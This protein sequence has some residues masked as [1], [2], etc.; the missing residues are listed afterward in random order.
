M[1]YLRPESAPTH[2]D[3]RLRLAGTKGIIEYQASTGVTLVSGERPPEII[4]E[5]P[6]EK[7]LFTDFLESI[8]LGKVPRLTETDVFRVNEIVLLARESADH[9]RIVRL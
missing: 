2:G 5:L 7:S 3:D 1:D 8:Y 4:K 6:E 9:H